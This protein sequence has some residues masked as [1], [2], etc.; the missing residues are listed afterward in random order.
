MKEP[1]EFDALCDRCKQWKETCYNVLYYR[2][3]RVTPPPTEFVIG[4]D[5]IAERVVIDP[6]D[7]RPP[8]AIMCRECRELKAKF[9]NNRKR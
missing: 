6:V 7:I 5:Y 4:P 2:P 1:G 9:D 8:T 3:M